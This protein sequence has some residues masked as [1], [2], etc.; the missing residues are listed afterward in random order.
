MS[1]KN[2]L[3]RFKTRWGFYRS[4]KEYL[5]RRVMVENYLINYAKGSK[6]MSPDIAYQLALHLAVPSDLSKFNS[7]KER[8]LAKG[9]IS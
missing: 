9:L 4:S 6:E 8:L 1:I 3:Q 2:G 5:S 7:L